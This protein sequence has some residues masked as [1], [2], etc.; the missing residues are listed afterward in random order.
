LLN[1]TDYQNIPTDAPQWFGPQKKSKIWKQQ[2]SMGG[3]YF[4][5]SDTGH[6]FIYE[7]QL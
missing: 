7:E 4:E 3:I 6:L 5:D 1:T 2:N